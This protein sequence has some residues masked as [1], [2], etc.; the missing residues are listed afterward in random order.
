MGSSEPK[1]VGSD[2]GIITSPPGKIGKA[3]TGDM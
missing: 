1:R 2:Y 3:A